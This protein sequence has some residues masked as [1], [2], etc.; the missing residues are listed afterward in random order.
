M[1]YREV[2]LNATTPE[3]ASSP[4]NPTSVTK[5]ASS[6]LQ[7]PY[8]HIGKRLLD[9]TVCLMAAPFVVPIVMILAL[10]IKRDG[11]KAFYTQDRVGRGGQRYKMW[12]LRSMVS[13]A[14]EILEAH[15]A[16]DPQARAEWN[17]DQKLKSDPRI[18]KF[19]N[20]LR[21]SSLDEL[22][23]LWNVVRGEMSLVGPRPMMTCQ[24]ALYP[25]KE[26]Y[27][28]LPGISGNWQVSDRNASSFADRA[29]YDAAY[30]KNMSLRED[31][32]IL[33][34]TVGVVLK[35]TGY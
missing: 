13:N 15:L 3:A 8:R 20:V 31:L 27:E 35:A 2:S 16:A 14:D 30:R 22:P 34:D 19:G 6:F 11:G 10:F 21:K 1:H 24:E 5:A 23:Q 7:D 32:R 9:L 25:G 18:T 28:L 4:N 26:Y 12:K 17:K 29:I 33:K